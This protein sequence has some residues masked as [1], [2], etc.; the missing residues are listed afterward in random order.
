MYLIV[1]NLLANLGIPGFLM[2]FLAFLWKSVVYLTT[3]F[4]KNTRNYDFRDAIE[5]WF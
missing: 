3:L 2:I 1:F 5:L 4:H